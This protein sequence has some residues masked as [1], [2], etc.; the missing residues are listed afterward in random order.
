MKRFLNR[1][2]RWHESISLLASNSLTGREKVEVEGH[3]ASC[4]HC[5]KFFDEVRATTSPLAGWETHFA[6]VEPNQAAQT[7]WAKAIRGVAETKPIRARLSG[8]SFHKLWAE[9]IWPYRRTWTGLAAVWLA[10]LVFNSSPSGRSQIVTAKS[11][12]L[13]GEMRLA[14]QE[15]RRVLAELIG[16]SLSLSPAEPPRRPNNQ[17]RSQLQSAA[18]A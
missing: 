11:T 5:R 2:G 9:L 6:H 10:I 14:F 16:P 12:T 18:M 7:R 4:A 13:P 1:C 17:P 8:I 15:Q 3:L